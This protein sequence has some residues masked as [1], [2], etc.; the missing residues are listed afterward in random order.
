M[1]EALAEMPHVSATGEAQPEVPASVAPVSPRDA[2]GVNPAASAVAEEPAPVLA[3]ASENPQQPAVATAQQLDIPQKA[4]VPQPPPAMMAPAL[5]AAASALVGTAVPRV[6]V[7]P[8]PPAQP[9]QLPQ[10]TQQQHTVPT[11]LP[12]PPPVGMAADWKSMY[13]KAVRERDQARAEVQQLRLSVV[14]L[15][16]LTAFVGSG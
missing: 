9:Q 13:E 2:E 14:R 7:T 4:Q 16:S 10:Q 12:S 1:A 5:P 8:H 11:G 6:A 15:C 3:G